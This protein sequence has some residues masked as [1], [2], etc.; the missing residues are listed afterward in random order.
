MVH[1]Y[2]LIIFKKCKLLN[3]LKVNKR[4]LKKKLNIF[5]G[6]LDWALDFSYIWVHLRKT[7]KF[8]IIDRAKPDVKSKVEAQPSHPTTLAKHKEGGENG[9]GSCD[10]AKSTPPHK[11]RVIKNLLNIISKRV[12]FINFYSTAKCEM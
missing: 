6:L 8:M 7:Q 11:T 4:K 3:I 9:F 5:T 10:F 1:I 2:F 12:L